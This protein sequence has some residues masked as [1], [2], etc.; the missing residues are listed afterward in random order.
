MAGSFL[1]SEQFCV[2]L[3]V[4]FVWQAQYFSMLPNIFCDS[5]SFLC[6]RCKSLAT[7]MTLLSFCVA[8]AIFSMSRGSFS[9]P[10]CHFVWQ[11][12]YSNPASEKYFVTPRSFC[13]A[14]AI[15]SMPPRSSRDLDPGVACDPTSFFCVAGAIFFDASEKFCW[16]CQ[17]LVVTLRPFCVACAIISLPSDPTHLVWPYPPS[18]W[19]HG[20]QRGGKLW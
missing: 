8:G 9:W 20:L 3:Y 2:T 4:L 16:Y 17:R 7:M 12:H 11:V 5:T 15:C 13:V 1:A 14:G 18:S 19:K 6:G 10:Y